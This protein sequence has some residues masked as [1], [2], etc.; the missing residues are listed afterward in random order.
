[1]GHTRVGKQTRGFIGTQS[2]AIHRS[3][4]GTCPCASLRTTAQ[5]HLHLASR[6]ET[7]LSHFADKIDQTKPCCGLPSAEASCA[8]VESYS[9]PVLFSEVARVWAVTVIVE[10]TPSPVR[11][12]LT[13][14]HPATGGEANGWRIL[15]M[16]DPSE[17]NTGLPSSPTNSCPNPKVTSGTQRKGVCVRTNAQFQALC[18]LQRRERSRWE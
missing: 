4:R 15:K 11:H 9:L 13:H 7:D 12:Q 10:L 2:H 17:I 14:A 16:E 3:A 1:M 5:T 8:D 6:P 18:R